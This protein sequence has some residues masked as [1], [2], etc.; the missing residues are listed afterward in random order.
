MS[1]SLVSLVFIPGIF[2]SFDSIFRKVLE[3]CGSRS[4]PSTRRTIISSRRP[5]NHS[6]ST[7]SIYPR[8]RRDVLLYYRVLKNERGTAGILRVLLCV[9][10]FF[11]HCQQNPI[12]RRK[13]SR[14]AH[15][16]TLPY[17]NRIDTE[18]STIWLKVS[19][20]L[21]MSLLRYRGLVLTNATLLNMEANRFDSP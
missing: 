14:T 13:H 19:I 7:Q 9:Y 1:R 6:C 15:F 21:A 2:G 8:H 20:I 12:T 5:N 10:W 3:N 17:L 18:P 4:G 16:N 11:F